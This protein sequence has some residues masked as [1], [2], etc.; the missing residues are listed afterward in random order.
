MARGL[1]LQPN[2]FCL[3]AALLGNYLLTEEELAEFHCRLASRAG[4]GKVGHPADTAPGSSTAA[5][6]VSFWSGSKRVTGLV[7]GLVVTGARPGQVGAEE[8]TGLVVEFVRSL[9]SADDLDE[10]SALV[11]QSD[12]A[13]PR[14]DRL[15]RSVR[16]YTDASRD[17]LKYKP[18]AR[19]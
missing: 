14:A 11:F 2:R 6:L 1:D 15:R 3:L 9:A 8:L 13:D 4:H 17:D 12:R 10:V 7:V 18:A 5:W 16:Y 19:E